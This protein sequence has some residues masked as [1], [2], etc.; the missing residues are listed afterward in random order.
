VWEENGNPITRR[1][2]IS[3]ERRQPTEGVFVSKQFYE[4]L[5]ASKSN[6]WHIRVS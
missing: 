5:I 4:A 6:E 3:E 1:A 2:D